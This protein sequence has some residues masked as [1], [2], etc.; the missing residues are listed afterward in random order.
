ML[1]ENQVPSENKANAPIF[2]SF[3]FFYKDWEARS[4]QDFISTVILPD[5]ILPKHYYATFQ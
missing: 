2:A 4:F 5:V 1:C 3:D